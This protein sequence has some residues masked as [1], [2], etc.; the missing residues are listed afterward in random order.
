[1]VSD[2]IPTLI[3][4]ALMKGNERDLPRIQHLK[5]ALKANKHFSIC[6]II[7]CKDKQFATLK[8]FHFEMVKIRNIPGTK[9]CSLNSECFSIEEE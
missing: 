5:Q 2:P 9:C 7:Q 6:H 4:S 3:C 8:H 1:M